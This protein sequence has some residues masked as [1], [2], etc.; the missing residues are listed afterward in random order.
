MTVSEY[1]ICVRD[2]SDNI[3]RFV[4]KHI[5]NVEKA[6]DI[7][8]DVF[9]K[10][11]VKVED[12]SFEKAKSYLFQAAYNTMIDSI[13]KDSKLHFSAEV[14]SDER[15]YQKQTDLQEVL[16][17]ALKRLP[18]IQQSVVLLRDY[19]G[20]S[21]EE[22]GEILSLNESQVKVYIFRARKNLREYLKKIEYVIE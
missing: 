18:Q 6:E 20:Y 19:E 21:Y 5:R 4:L 22:I 9:E 3:Y 10:V 2:Y 1:N 7:V 8:Q 15:S 13:R 17:D 16:H 14:E 11:W 12:V